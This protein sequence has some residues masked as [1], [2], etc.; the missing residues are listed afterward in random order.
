[1]KRARTARSCRCTEPPASDKSRMR[2]SAI[3]TVGVCLPTA[4]A[5]RSHRVGASVASRAQGFRHRSRYA[6]DRLQ[7]INAFENSLRAIIIGQR[8]RL[9]AVFLKTNFQGLFRVI[10]PYGVTVDL[11][12]SGPIENATQQHFFVNFQFEHTVEIEFFGQQYIVE[13]RGLGDRSGK[14]IQNEASSHW[15]SQDFS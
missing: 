12:F 5:T 3:V 13:R 15:L 6:I 1:M 2:R 4:K 10:C 8:L 9:P 14:S 7:T 11:R